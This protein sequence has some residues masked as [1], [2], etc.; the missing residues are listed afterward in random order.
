MVEITVYSALYTICIMNNKGNK[1]NTRH[2]ILDYIKNSDAVRSVD[3]DAHFDINRQMAHCHLKALIESSKIKKI[4][5]ALKTFYTA[6][7]E[8]IA[9][10]NYQLEEKTQQIIAKIFFIEPT[11]EELS[12]VVG[13][14]KWCSKRG[15]NTN[16]IACKPK[17]AQN[18]SKVIGFAVTGSLNDFEVIS[19]V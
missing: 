16:Q 1:S 6:I 18:T 13:F 15:F 8:D 12:G 19:E 2:R 9:V 7:N 11:G 5:V 10:I 4:G 17:K 14:E 3:I